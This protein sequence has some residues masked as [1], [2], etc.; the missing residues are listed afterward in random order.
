MYLC[1]EAITWVLCLAFLHVQIID[2]VFVQQLYS[3]CDGRVVNLFVQPYFSIIV[4]LPVA[5]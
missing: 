2:F 4:L 3:L 1:A 5:F